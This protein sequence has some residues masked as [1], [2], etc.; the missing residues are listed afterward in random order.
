M[1]KEGQEKKGNKVA[2]VSGSSSGIGLA[3]SLA[4]ARNGFYTYATMRNLEKSAGIIDAAAKEKLPLQLVQLDV[5]DERSVN[6]A[7]AKITAEQGRI[8]VLVNNAGYGLFGALEDLSIEEIKAQ[9]ETNFFGLIRLTQAALPLMRKQNGGIIVN[10]G[11]VA[12]RIGFPGTAAYTS[13]KFALEGLTEAISYE[14]EPFGIKVVIVEPGVIKTNFL[15]G[16]VVPRKTSDPNS[17]YLQLMQQMNATLSSM[18]ENGSSSP[19]VVAKAV[20]Q[21]VTVENPELRYL[22]GEDAVTL[23]EMRKKAPSD[24]EFRQML[25]QNFS[26]H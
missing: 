9:Y 2:V 1:Q 18:R 12:G 26:Q 25:K 5:N 7:I 16:M 22:A 13:T 23:M 3:T 14:L 19:E 10:V 4:L 8:D 17:P 24:E 6:S 11:S 20:L 15:N 21:A